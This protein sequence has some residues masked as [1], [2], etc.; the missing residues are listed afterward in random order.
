MSMQKLPVYND[1]S[2]RQMTQLEH[3]RAKSSMY[4]DSED[5]GADCQL[6]K[7]II[8]NSADE[9][10]LSDHVYNIKVV[11]FVGKGRYQVCIIDYGRG[12]PCNKLKIIYTEAFSSGKY[13]NKAYNGISTGTFGIGSKC[14]TALSRKFVAI[15]K[16]SDGFAG[17]TVEQGVV[18][19]NIVTGPIDNNP[20]TVGTTVLYET[21]QTILKESDQYIDSPNGLAVSIKLMEYI[22]AFKPN[23][24]FHVY[25]VNKLLPNTWFEQSYVDMWNYL[26]NITGD[27]IFK[28]PDIIDPFSYSR[29]QYNITSPTMWNL[30]LFKPVDTND[31]SDILG[32]DIHVGVAKDCEKQNGILAT[33]NSNLINT[34]ISSH[35]S[36]LVDK[37]K[38]KIVQYLDEDDE[39]LRV[40]FDT[41]YT[42]PLHGYICAYCKSPKF[43]GQTKKSFKDL[44]FARLYGQYIDKLVK[45]EPDDYWGNLYDLV[46]NDLTKKFAASEN[47][48][49]NTGKSLKNAAWSMKNEGC[50]IPCKINSPDITELLITEGN[51]AGDWVKQVRNSTF[52]A[53]LK[54]RGKPINA[55]IADNAALKANAVYQDMVRLFGVTPRDTDLSNFNFKKVGLLA[56]ADPDGYHILS[57]LIGSIYKI[58]P[59]ILESGRVFIANPPLYVLES[60]DRN[61]FLRDQKALDDSRVM[62]YDN[63]FEIALCNVTTKTSAKLHDQSFRDFVY[64]IKRLGTVINDVATKLVIDPFVLEQLVGCVDY[65]SVYNLNCDKIKEQ[66]N[67]ESCSYH[68]IANTLLLVSDGME[69]SVPLNKLVQEI[70][71]YILPEIKPVHWESIIPVVTTKFAD[72]YQNEP[73]TYMQIYNI[74]NEIDTAY[75]VRR[76]KGLGECTPEQ[77]LY[78]CVDPATRTYTTI[79]SIG[80]VEVLFKLLGVDTELRKSLVVKDLNNLFARED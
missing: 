14:C 65:L 63:F 26:Q 46:V 52:Q 2:I 21:D 55:I 33:V 64:L 16:R 20:D 28:T 24:K 4:I 7:E 56:D 76:L 22:G 53:V 8:D 59:L 13:S 58:N 19:D 10:I 57:L 44:E 72:T 70:K 17:L 68:E 37:L 60:N 35:I 79:T 15:S 23:T 77:L 41:K 66:L 5:V 30:T 48:I 43:E 9:S 49:L 42:L 12:I 40:Y 75:P 3:L 29:E 18:K 74:F 27:L 32:F 31:E 71:A 1:G 38:S 11:F 62:I 34:P 25:R 69:I 61:L 80:D 54:M 51:S 36:V 6:F 78:T 73:L 47:R 45:N 50:F 67:L 39:E